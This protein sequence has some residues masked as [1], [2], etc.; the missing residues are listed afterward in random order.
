[1]DILVADPQ[2][3]VDLGTT[4]LRIISIHE[5]HRVLAEW[6]SLYSSLATAKSCDWRS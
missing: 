1:L 3:R 4:S 6:E 5:Q 2:R